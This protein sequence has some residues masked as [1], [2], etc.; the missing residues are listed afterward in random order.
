MV[1]EVGKHF[2]CA[3]LAGTLLGGVGAFGARKV[4]DWKAPLS[5]PVASAFMAASVSSV[6]RVI[7]KKTELVNKLKAQFGDDTYRYEECVLMGGTLLGT[8]VATYALAP[9]FTS[10]SFHLM[11][12]GSYT[13]TASIGAILSYT[14]V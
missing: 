3:L 13:F 8:L 10:R 12:T 1:R 5:G 11:E 6:L 7:V 14:F 9:K 2:A 4:F